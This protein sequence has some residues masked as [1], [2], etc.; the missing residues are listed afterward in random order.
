MLGS[1]SEIPDRRQMDSAAITLV[2]PP[3]V[4]REV[5]IHLHHQPVAVDLGH[6]GGGGDGGDQTVTP[7]QAA[8]GL[9]GIEAKVSVDQV[10]VGLGCREQA[11]EGGAVRPTH[12]SSVDLRRAHLDH[13]DHHGRRPDE[14][15]K[16]VALSWR[17]PFA[18]AQKWVSEVFWKDHRRCHQ[19]PSKSAPA[20][21]I[22]PADLRRSGA[23][24]VPVKSSCHPGESIGP[25]ALGEEPGSYTRDQDE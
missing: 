3:L 4:V 23:A 10:L 2:G 9:W 22:H 15:R 1:R 5:P 8:M 21:L 16:P 18:V 24:R 7:D 25:I 17:E 12:P 14:W 20:D 11:L 19:R 13:Q 6:H